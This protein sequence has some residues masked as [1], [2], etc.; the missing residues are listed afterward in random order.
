[1][2]FIQIK[3]VVKKYSQQISVDH[4]NL[5][6]QEGEIFGLLGPNGAGK[7]TTIKMLSGLLK[8]D[9]GEMIVDGLSV[10]KDPLE[11]KRLIGLVPQELA[12]F[13]S[14]SARE[15][16]TFFARL[17]GLRGALLQSRV[18]EALE[19]VGLS[20]R[21]ND[22]PNAFSGGM[23]RRLNIACAIM[24]HPK[25][26]IMDEPTVGIDPQSRNHILESVKTLNRMGSTIIYTSHYMEE[27]AAISTRVGIMD[28]GHLIACGTQEELRGKVAQ[29]N[30]VVLQVAHLSEEA[31]KELR[32]HPKI[33]QVN[34]Q[35]QALE[36]LV[37]SSQAYLQDILFILSK[38]NVK[39]Q[40]LVQVEPDLEA[41]FL[42][43]TGR[44]LRD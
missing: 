20:D 24:H 33:K 32:D 1:M 36:L 41:L 37:G 28:H 17:Y 29:D 12:I 42:S 19:F 6:I 13:E 43:L 14:L 8:I 44:T 23:K 15:N 3:N 34:A 7:S 38:H 25:L 27:V 21:A 5:S 22:K 40:S 11:V 30:K 39:I 2:S 10:A 9:G 31:V 26:I 35:E 18:K 16:V 4:L